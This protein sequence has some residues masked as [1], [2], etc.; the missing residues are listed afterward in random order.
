MSLDPTR[1][2]TFDEI[3]AAGEPQF[4]SADP[5]HYKRLLVAE[6]ERLAERKLYEGQV[7]MYMIEVMAYA[8]QVRGAELQFAVVQRLLPFAS[9]RFLDLLAARLGV[10]RLKATSA[11]MT[12]RFTLVA[13]RPD[14]T[15]IGK[16]TRVRAEGAAGVFLTDADLLVQP[17]SLSAVVRAVAEAPGETANGVLPGAALAIL[18]PVAG[19]ARAEAASL[20]E[21]GALEEGDDRLRRRAAQAWE[22]I[23][24]GGPREGY[25]QRALEAH[26]AILDVAIVRPQPC[27][28]RIY[29][30]TEVLPLGQEIIDAVYAACDPYKG[31]PEGDEVFVL[32]PTAVTVSPTLRLWIDGDVATIP[33]QA[34]A[35]ARGVFEV[36]RRSLGARLSTAAIVAPVKRIPGVVEAV[37]E[38]FTFRDLAD[39]EFAVLASLTVVTGQL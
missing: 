14:T 26:P 8:L 36:W 9:G 30:L 5:L 13:P 21:G 34:E 12:V 38:G 18:D 3:V 31:R 24:R 4:F 2:Y 17:G 35:T 22:R 19:V 10:Y 28:I 33:A 25:R 1:A 7:E 16:G 37:V 32:A 6:F 27:D 11:A 29:P 15:I 20:S 39:D 23:S